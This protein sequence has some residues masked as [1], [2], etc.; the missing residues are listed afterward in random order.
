VSDKKS[1]SA[2]QKL[3]G[4]SREEKSAV[5]LPKA[6]TRSPAPR[7]QK[8]PGQKKGQDSGQSQPAS[9]TGRL[10]LWLGATCMQ[11]WDIF[12]LLPSQSHTNKS[13][14]CVYAGSLPESIP[15]LKLRNSLWLLQMVPVN[16]PV[17]HQKTGEAH[18]PAASQH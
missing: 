13:N 14:T 3:S 4:S 9:G 7:P 16:K 1:S 2:G 5:K 10:C 15:S 17:P 18:A 11:S 6:A 8:A 12:A